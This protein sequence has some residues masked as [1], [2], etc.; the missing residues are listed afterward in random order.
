MV[1]VEG[2]VVAPLA[3]TMI[4]DWMLETGEP[5]EELI[6]SAGLRLV[7]PHGPADIQVDP[8]RTGRDRTT[9]CCRCCSR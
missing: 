5:L 1:R 2:A 9:A 6:E 3:A 8:V 4:G 7:E